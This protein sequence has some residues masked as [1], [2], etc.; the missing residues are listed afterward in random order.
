MREKG[1]RREQR[2]VANANAQYC[3]VGSSGGLA[4]RVSRENAHVCAHTGG[5]ACQGLI[6]SC[7]PFRMHA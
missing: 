3:R 4:G 2:A 5:H 1:E 6:H 7:Y